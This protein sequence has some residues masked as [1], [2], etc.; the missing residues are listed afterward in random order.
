MECINMT[1]EQKIPEIFENNMPFGIEFDKS[2]IIYS[3]GDRED[4]ETIIA[5]IKNG[6]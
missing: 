3:F 5:D 1:N 2:K 4:F 6:V